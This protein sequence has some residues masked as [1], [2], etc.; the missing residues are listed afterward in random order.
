M[1]DG[2]TPSPSLAVDGR[3]AGICTAV[4][5][6]TRYPEWSVTRVRSRSPTRRR[7]ELGS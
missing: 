7:T 4:W 5:H 1:M 6:G 2:P 3:N